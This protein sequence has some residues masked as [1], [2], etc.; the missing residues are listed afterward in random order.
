MADHQRSTSRVDRLVALGAVATL[1]IATALAF[2]RVFEGGGAMAKLVVVAAGSTLVAVALERRSLPLATAVSVAVLVL[3]IAW[4]VFPET[5]RYGL[6]SRQTLDAIREALGQVGRQAQQ[7]VS[8]TIPLSPLLLAAVTAV[9]ASAFSIHA[10]AV[11]AGSPLLALIPSVALIGFADSALEG[12]GAPAFA[13]LFLIGALT[14]LLADGTRRVRQWGTLR[15]WSGPSGRS[16]SLVARG[17]GSVAAVTVIAALLVPGLL[18]GFGAGGWIDLRSVGGDSTAIDPLV[19]IKAELVQHA[20]R[21]LFEVRAA[22]ESYW[23]MLA[24]DRFDGSTWSTADLDASSSPTIPVDQP[25]AYQHPPGSTSFV[26]H[27]TVRTDLGGPWIPAAY[28]PTQIGLDQAGYRYNRQLSMAVAIDPLKAGDSYTATS[29]YVVPTPAQLEA[30]RFQPADAYGAL[31]QLPDSIPPEIGQIARRWTAGLGSAYEEVL[32]IQNHLLGPAFSYDATVAPS[33]DNDAMVQ[34]LTKTKRGFCQQFASTMAVLVRSIGLPAR[35]A[36][37]F[38]PGT[39]TGNGGYL[40]STTNAHAWVEV[41]FPGYGWLA[42]EPTPGRSNPVAQPYVAPPT[43][44]CRGGACAGGT[45]S[46]GGSL[47]VLRR[48]PAL[49]SSAR[50][51]GTGDSAKLTPAARSRG[52]PL[53][54][55]EV[56]LALL[57]VLLA[58]AILVP[59]VKLVRRRLRIASAREPRALT[60]ATY[61]VF[62]A[63]AG[64]LGLGRGFGETMREYESRLRDATPVSDAHLAQ[65]TTIASRAAYS[66]ASVDRGEA[67]DAQRAARLAWRD[68]RRS[69]GLRRRLFGVYRTGL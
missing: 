23:R 59:P 18:P 58:F 27:V 61:D 28:S 53:P 49:T 66:P 8:P 21:E 6:P 43:T 26:Q 41:A 22:R 32:A 9:W 62:S 35:V 39:P 24:L 54:V 20:P 51:R 3:A 2:A 5:A 60:L 11:R 29:E 13:A 63:R 25:I 15:P 12:R 4:L 67:A 37:G 69:R 30:V 14:V 64:D 33:A 48:D 40:V 1:A 17:A 56:L 55:G 45:S 34:F 42:F 7:Q 19:S 16:R 57:A 68:L 50:R 31:T 52:G 38:T 46:Q 36:V 65:L 47:P 44:G 10:L